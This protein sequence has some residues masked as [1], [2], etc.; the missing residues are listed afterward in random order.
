MSNFYSVVK[1]LFVLWS[2]L[3]QSPDSDHLP[4]CP[5]ELSKCRSADATIF[6]CQMEISCTHKACV[7]F[8]KLKQEFKNA[9]AFLF[10]M[11]RGWTQL[12]D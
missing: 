12:V 9:S 8:P 5:F 2:P 1:M 11:Q 7:K 6:K 4:L 3:S 10:P